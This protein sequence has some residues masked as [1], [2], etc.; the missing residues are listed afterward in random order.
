[1]F[2]SSK[3]LDVKDVMI[4]INQ[5]IIYLNFKHISVYLFLLYKHFSSLQQAN[6]YIIAITAKLKSA[7]YII[8]YLS[9]YLNTPI[10]ISD[11]FFIFQDLNTEFFHI[12]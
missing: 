2:I 4:Q 1:M 8:Y 6:I 10:L 3:G 9:Y 12:L 7:L 5:A 11:L